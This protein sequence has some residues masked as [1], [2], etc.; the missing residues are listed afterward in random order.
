R[1]VPGVRPGASAGGLGGQCRAAD[2]GRPG[3]RVARRPAPLARARLC[4]P[5]R[6]RIRGD[7]RRRPLGRA[8]GGPRGPGAVCLAPGGGLGWCAWLAGSARDPWHL[9]AL[10][11]AA[12]LA[13]DPWAVT[14][15]G[16]QLSFAAVAA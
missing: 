16:F 3:A 13:L 7:R 5:R 1:R 11:G 2:R 8:R 14:G 12:V 10:A 15:P 6:G 9:L 4:D